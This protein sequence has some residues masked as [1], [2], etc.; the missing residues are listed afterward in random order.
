MVS[1]KSSI[2]TN[3]CNLASFKKKFVG[4]SFA[5]LFKLFRNKSVYLCIC[6]FVNDVIIYWQSSSFLK[7]ASTVWH[8]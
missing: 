6:L 7:S 4:C 8:C 2:G 1:G 3:L 5:V